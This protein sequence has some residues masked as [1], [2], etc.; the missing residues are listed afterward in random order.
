M[1]K[2]VR[3]YL[4]ETGID[5]E[6]T[7]V[8]TGNVSKTYRVNG[9]PGYFIQVPGH[10][11]SLRRGILAL[12]IQQ[13]TDFP[14][15]E[16][17]HYDMDEPFLIT[18]ALPGTRLQ[19]STD[20]DLYRQT[21]RLLA[22]L[23]EQ[24]HGYETYGLL[25]PENGKLE[26]E[27]IQNWRRGLDSIFNMYMGNADKLIPMTEASRLDSYYMENRTNIP[28]ERPAELGHFDFHGDNIFQE[29]GEITGVL[30]WDMVRVI[31]PALEA[32]KTQRQFKRDQRPHEAFIQAYENERNL[33]VDEDVQEL[34]AMVSEVSRL[35]EL[36]YLK[37]SQGREPRDHEIESAMQE[38]NRIIET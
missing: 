28:S 35:S 26:A 19:E 25:N 38:I 34:Y 9:E 29:D 22:Q 3:G 33:G 13:E 20:K 6:F 32:I 27:G 2:S 24:D 36:Q 8:E 18:R 37:Q 17:V 1:K 10:E 30:D 23:H 11:E 15:P 21:G 14:V 31:D 4:E 12:E 7:E 16:I 5:Q